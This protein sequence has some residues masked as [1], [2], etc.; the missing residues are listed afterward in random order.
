MV[1]PEI[2]VPYWNTTTD[3]LDQV[4]VPSV[5]M[6][7]VG[8]SDSKA[9]ELRPRDAFIAPPPPSR[10]DFGSDIEHEVLSITEAPAQ[11]PIWMWISVSLAL[12]W[13]LTIAWALTLRRPKTPPAPETSSSSD[14]TA[15]LA[16]AIDSA[17]HNDAG[18]CLR[19]LHRLCKMIGRN[20]GN[21][22]VSV[23]TLGAQLSSTPLTQEITRLMESAYS[24]TAGAW[25]GSALAKLLRQHRS[26]IETLDQ[27]QQNKP[28]LA[29]Y[30]QT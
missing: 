19:D 1:L 15:A 2:V 20:A 7:I 8:A 10:D 24:A 5:K 16:G 25:D 14:L 18:Q 4:V 29:L 13:L 27:A 11:D 28:S 22:P 6:T 21:R 30:P 17:R 9:Q 23:D 3:S 12:L 26:D